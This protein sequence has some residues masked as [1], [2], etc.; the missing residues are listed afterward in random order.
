MMEKN[1]PAYSVRHVNKII[2]EFDDN[3]VSILEGSEAKEWLASAAAANCYKS[4]QWLHIYPICGL[5]PPCQLC[6]REFKV[7]GS[8]KNL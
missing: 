1:I 7:D 2:L 5:R 6:M 4:H 8:T 3:T